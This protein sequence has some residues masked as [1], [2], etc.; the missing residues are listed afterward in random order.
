[1]ESS[2]NKQA[3]T[4]PGHTRP[5]DSSDQKSSR[6][7]S[8]SSNGDSNDTNATSHAS[9]PLASSAMHFDK[10]KT[11][12]ALPEDFDLD[13]SYD[14]DN[15]TEM[16]EKVSDLLF[17]PLHLQAIFKDPSCLLRF[18]SFLSAYRPQSIPTLIYY[19]DAT[20]ALKAIR[21]ANTVASAL[22]SSQEL[23]LISTKTSNSELEN[24]AKKA[25]DLLA[26]R[27]L[28]AYTAHIYIQ[29]VKSSM[30]KPV[31]QGPQPTET[32]EGFAEVFCLTDPSRPDNPIVFA[33]EGIILYYIW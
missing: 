17:S 12:D 15:Q 23:P 10:G 14:E 24:R 30:M 22:E 3:S 6:D 33:S 1:M 29:V 32:P 25:F 16:L 31:P 5:D 28:P 9:L 8:L 2:S 4:M 20:K 27:D 18:T 13:A 21:Y 7:G 26:E 19:L 11:F